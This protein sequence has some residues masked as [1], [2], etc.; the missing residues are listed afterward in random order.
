VA[1]RTHEVA[2]DA[3]SGA[4]LRLWR[5]WPEWVGYATVAWSL[6][7]GSLELYW[8]LGGAGFPFGTQS[9]PNAAAESITG[10]AQAVFAPLI[11]AMGLVGTVIAVSMAR[12]WRRGKRGLFRT[13]MLAFAWGA[14]IA[15]LLVIPDLRVL[16]AA[17]YAPIFLVGAPFGWPPAN[18]FETALPWPVINQLVCIAGG[19]LWAGTAVA[20]GRKTRDACA[21]CGRTDAGGGWSTPAAATRWGRWAAYVA[22]IVPLPYAAIRLAWALGYPLGIT[23]ELLREGQQIG[24]WWAG[25]AL[26]TVDL[27]GAFLTLGLVRSWGEVFPR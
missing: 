4:A 8:A 12:R 24:L 17:A 22:V 6:A 10:G 15:L 19:F 9:D 11:A 20:Y 26:S 25:A 2:T 27:A 7:Y 3:A 18:Y 21:N 13:A 1:E 16:M 5:R 14:S 23:E